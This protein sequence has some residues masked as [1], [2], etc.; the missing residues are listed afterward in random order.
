LVVEFGSLTKLAQD[1]DAV[2][3]TSHEEVSHA[4][5]GRFVDP[6]VVMEGC[7]GNRDDALNVTR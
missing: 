2:D 3:A 7:R 5:Q 6:A 1:G 4:V